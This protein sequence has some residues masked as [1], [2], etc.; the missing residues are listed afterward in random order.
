MILPIA[1][2]LGFET[3]VF[4]GLVALHRGAQ[5]PWEEIGV[6]SGQCP[7]SVYHLLGMGSRSELM[8]VRRSNTNPL[9]ASVRLCWAHFRPTAIQ[10]SV[11]RCGVLIS[12]LSQTRIPG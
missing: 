12:F 4:G 7:P 6:F 3:R 9:L 8:M 2:Q 1:N 5:M 11:H 10:L